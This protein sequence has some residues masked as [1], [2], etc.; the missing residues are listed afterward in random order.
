MQVSSY[1]TWQ[2]WM[3]AAW[4]RR[5]AVQGF[6]L[7]SS[8]PRSLSRSL[9]LLIGRVGRWPHSLSNPSV[10][11]GPAVRM[12]ASLSTAAGSKKGE[13][14]QAIPSELF[15]PGTIEEGRAGST[16]GDNSASSS[17]ARGGRRERGE[18]ACLGT[19]EVCDGKPHRC[20]PA[21]SRAAVPAAAAALAEAAAAGRLARSFSAC[22][23]HCISRQPLAT[24][25]SA[26]KPAFPLPTLVCLAAQRMACLHGAWAPL[27]YKP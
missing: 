3:A 13:R 6:H 14:L 20:R 10:R 2:S 7:A 4:R 27:T 16:K 23:M 15:T 24:C 12:G 9:S 22:G 1:P 8:A 25:L 17:S 19:L 11:G 21:D 26:D 5:Q 18:E